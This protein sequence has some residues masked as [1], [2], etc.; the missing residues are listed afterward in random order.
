MTVE[1]DCHV[2]R[3][4]NFLNSVWNRASA[5]LAPNEFRGGSLAAL[6]PP[7]E[8]AVVSKSSLKGVPIEPWPPAL[9]NYESEARTFES[10]RARQFL[11][12]LQAFRPAPPF[13]DF[14]SNGVSNGATW[15]SAL[16]CCCE[17]VPSRSGIGVERCSS[18]AATVMI[19]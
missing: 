1:A 19:R 4:A 7:I 9:P 17:G 15:R 8:D 3:S 6:S 18:P 16:V 2:L 13:E 12:Y 14:F 10:F 5:E 11:T